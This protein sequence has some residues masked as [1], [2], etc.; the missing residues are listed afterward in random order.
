VVA[1]KVLRPDRADD[2]ALVKRFLREAR[3]IGRL[4]HPNIVTIHDCGEDHGNVYIA[5]EFLDGRPL[6]EL[7]AE[8]RFSVPEIVDIGIQMA[9]TLDYAHEKGVV[10]TGH[11]PSNIV[12]APDHR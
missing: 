6:N 10:P 8:R 5:M 1:L 4:S 12:L 7:L 2:E 11:Q 3:A 9:E